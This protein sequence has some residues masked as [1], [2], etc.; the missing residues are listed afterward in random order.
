MDILHFRAGRS[1]L[2]LR[3]FLYEEF[4]KLSGGKP[5]SLLVHILRRIVELTAGPQ[6]P[7]YDF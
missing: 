6:S 1:P 5:I 7:G 4:W 3:L 2:L